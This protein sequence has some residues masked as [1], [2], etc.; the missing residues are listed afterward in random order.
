MD[1]SL[2]IGC[3]YFSYLSSAGRL[4]FQDGFGKSEGLEEKIAVAQNGSEVAV[5]LNEWKGSTFWDAGK[6]QTIAKSVSVYNLAQGKR[7]FNIE[8][9]PSPKSDLDYALSPEG[10]EVAIL[11]DRRVTVC[12]LPKQ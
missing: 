8:L 12:R 3:K 10:S 5:S 9:K 7:I 11:S 6:S 1:G 4:L 2:V